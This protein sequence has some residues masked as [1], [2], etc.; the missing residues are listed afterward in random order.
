MTITQ[1]AVER[2][3][4]IYM[5][6]SQQTIALLKPFAI[7]KPGIVISPGNSINTRSDDVV[8]EA[9]VL[10]TFPIEVRL[11]D[12]H[13]FVRLLS[14]LKSRFANSTETMCGLSNPMEH[15]RRYMPLESR[16]PCFI[17]QSDKRTHFQLN[18]L[19]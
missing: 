2:T 16:G 12:I 19:R 3:G 14:L 15:P 17:G 5:N 8:A 4:P 18:R 9:T 13:E 1:S 6:I 10:E 11:P 7:I